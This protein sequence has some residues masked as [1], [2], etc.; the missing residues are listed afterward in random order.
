[1]SRYEEIKVG[2][3]AVLRRRITGEDIEKFAAVTGDK[4]PVH[5]DEEYAKASFFGRRIAH[6]MLT[7]GL[8]SNLLGNVLPGPGTI[9][10]RQELRFLAPVYPGD[11]IEA[12]V[13]VLE[14]N[15]AK[16]ILRLKTSCRNQE[17]K[18]V[19]EGEALVML[20]G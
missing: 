7:A 20:P 5:L 10:L 14:K 9:Y 18:T 17:G 2:D 1:M 16:K 8:I 4:N 11:T 13:E 3:R 15:D 12:G 19:L 6:G